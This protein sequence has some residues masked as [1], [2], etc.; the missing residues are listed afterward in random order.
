[1]VVRTKTERVR[2]TRARRDGAPARQPPARLPDLRPGR[3]VQAPGLRLRVRRLRRRA[4]ASRAARSRRPSR[5]GRRSCS[6]RS[7]ASCA[8][9]ACASAAR[10]PRPASSACC[11]R[12]DDS[13]IETFPGS[14]LDNDYSMNVAD[15]CPVGALTPRTSASRSASGSSTTCP[16]SAP[17]ARTAATSISASRTTRSTATCRA[18]NDAVND[19][20]IC[21]EG[22]MS[23]KRIGAARPHA[24]RARARRARRA[25]GGRL[26]AAVAARRAAAA[27]LRDAGRRRGRGLASAH[28][29]NEDLFVLRRLL[30]ALG[31]GDVGRRVSGARARRRPAD[32]GREGRER[33]PARARSASRTRRRSR[34]DPR[35]RRRGR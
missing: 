5:S 3:R 14:P 33:A 30:D 25:G 26:L 20:W 17:A 15:I 29:T 12:G 34:A 24:A 1:M 4:P 16:A 2:E 19:T 7:A 32:Q 8:G 11:D 22:R 21:D 18:A 27:A 28:A 35:G 23:Y 13:V 31:T 6:T 10:C 9:A